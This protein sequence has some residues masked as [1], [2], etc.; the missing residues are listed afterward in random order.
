MSN[1]NVVEIIFSPTGGTEK[2]TNQLG[3]SLGKVKEVVHLNRYGVDFTDVKI[4]KEDLAVIAAPV[5][6]AVIPDMAIER[7]KQ[8]KGN[9]ANCVVVAV[10]GNRAYDDGLI[11]L[12][13]AAE[14]C[15]F[16]VVAAIAA[17]AEHSIMRQFGAG[18]PDSEDEKELQAFAEKIKEKLT[19]NEKINTDYFVPG[20]H[21]YKRIGNLN[22]VPKA[23]ENCISCGKCAAACPARAIDKNDIKTGD[24]EKC[25]SCMGCIA[26]GP[27]KARKLDSIFLA[28]ASAKMEPFLSGRKPNEI[29]L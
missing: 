12:K 27:V 4:E 16:Q 10:Y 14:L 18:R 19:E 26:A 24:G 2:V 22:V 28:A 15:G 11:Q 8:I 7:I 13:D 5:F 20:S 25:I 1:R 29:F 3:N 17:V 6:E 9:G 21:E 23:D